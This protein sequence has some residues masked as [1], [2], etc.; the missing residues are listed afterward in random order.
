M[1]DIRPLEAS[2]LSY[3]I[4]VTSR[5]F[6]PDP[7][8]G[9]FARSALHEHQ[10]MPV[11]I[12]ATMRDC[13]RH[14]EIDVAVHEGKVVGSASW[15]GPDLLP[16]STSRQLRMAAACAGALVTGRNRITGM[17]LLDQTQKQHPHEPHRY[18]ALLGVDP[19]AQGSGIGRA[20]LEP[21]LEQSDTEGLPVFLETQKRENL[22]FYARFGFTV[23]AELQ[24]R[25]SPTV[26]HL[27]REPRG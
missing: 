6:W 9:F 8:F 27:W 25:D 17:R 11:F 15:L 18:L 22:S 1:V 19:S 20:L 12:G 26:W 23:R 24:V 21:R 13:R 4:T 2:E 5:A 16:Q 14:G 10:L 7:L 3:A